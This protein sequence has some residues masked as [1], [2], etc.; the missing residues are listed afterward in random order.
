MIDKILQIPK[1]SK[2]TISYLISALCVTF[3]TYLYTS[4]KN[5]VDQDQLASSEAS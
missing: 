3:F 2:H 5:H 4:F 1:A